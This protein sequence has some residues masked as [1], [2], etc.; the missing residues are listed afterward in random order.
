MASGVSVE[1]FKRE[2]SV[3]AC[4]QHPHIVPILA[5]GETDGLPYFTMPFIDGETLRTRLTRS[6]EFPI[7][8]ALH[9]LRELASALA[10]AHRKG[11]VHR[12]IKPENILL[13]EQHVMVT[14]FGVAK[15]LSDATVGGSGGLTSVGIALG[16][17]AYM[18]HEQATADPMTDS[19][20]DIY[21]FGLIAYELL[22]GQGPFAGRTFQALIAAHVTEAPESVASRRPAI[23]AALA[24]LTMRCLAKR[25]A[26]RPQR[27]EDILHEVD[28]VNVSGAAARANIERR[29]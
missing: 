20:A 7:A 26:D 6:G 22:V 8:E 27:A 24:A 1:R 16:T 11:V 4:L 19:R 12:D 21:A 15:A 23:P 28:A 25:P 3:V 10:Y 29:Q 9:L 13:T 18:A 17:P 14:D 5:A 2:I